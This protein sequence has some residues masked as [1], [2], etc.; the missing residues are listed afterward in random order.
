MPAEVINQPDLTAP[1]VKSEPGTRDPRAG[2]TSDVEALL[3]VFDK[4]EAAVAADVAIAVAEAT[5]VPRREDVF[6]VVSADKN[7][8][9]RKPSR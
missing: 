9:L 1:L 3:D 7:Q 4:I 8:A 2:L 5:A 6:G